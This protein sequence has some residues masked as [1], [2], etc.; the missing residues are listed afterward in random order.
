MKIK[1]LVLTALVAA[2]GSQFA[3]ADQEINITGATAFRRAVMDAIAATYAA[4]YNVA[5]SNASNVDINAAGKVTFE[6]TY[7]TLPNKTTIRCSWNGSVEGVRALLHP[8]ATYNAS[9]IPSAGGSGVPQYSQAASTKYAADF[10]FSDV[11]RASTP[12]TG[13]LNPT[14][15]GIGIVVFSLIANN[16]STLTNITTNQF[17]DLFSQGYTRK[18]LLT[19]NNADTGRV[20]AVG[21]NDGSGT[22]T[23]YAASTGLG[24]TSLLKQYQAL[25]SSGST[26]TQL[27]IV[28]ED[29]GSINGVLSPTSVSTIWLNTAVGNGGYNSG[30]DLIKDMVKTT[31]STT[32]LDEFGD[33][34]GLG[35]AIDLVTFISSAD[36]LGKNVVVLNYNGVKVTPLAGSTL[37]SVEDQAKITQG[38]YEAWGTEQLYYRGT[39][40][41]DAGI[42]KTFYDGLVTNLKSPTYANL[43][44]VSIDAM[45]VNRTPTDGGVIAPKTR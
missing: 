13:T 20:F 23:T 14:D 36:I 32:V 29:G 22:R 19:G 31:A 40:G 24:V 15:A 38:L 6:G 37:F 7:G 35:G 4:G 25:A 10:A 18:F 8:G 34:T 12:E 45:S 41:S 27:Q 1:T 2:A 21:R 42:Y 11:T 33:N 26:I 17:K 30:G 5:S 28:P 43:C 9:Y 44:G 16:S 3:S 39:I